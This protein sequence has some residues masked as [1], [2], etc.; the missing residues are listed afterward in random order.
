MVE[1]ATNMHEALHYEDRRQF[2]KKF[3]E[4]MS[5]IHDLREAVAKAKSDNNETTEWDTDQATLNKLI[6]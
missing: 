6:L 3:T 5:K 2:F 4:S 1:I